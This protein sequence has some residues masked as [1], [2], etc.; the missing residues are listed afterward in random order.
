VVEGNHRFNGAKEAG[1][2]SVPC[3]VR[4]LTDQEVLV[5]QLKAQ[6]IRPQVSVLDIAKRLQELLDDGMT[7]AEL[8]HQVGKSPRWVRDRLLLRGMVKDAHALLDDGVLTVTS[9]VALAKLPKQIQKDVLVD[10]ITLPS[11]EFVEKAR[12]L[13]KDYREGVKQGRLEAYVNPEPQPY[14]RTMTEI[15]EEVC[16][17]R[18]A[19]IHLKMD[20]AQT[21]LDGWKS[22]IKWLL[23]LDPLSLQVQHDKHE[24]AKA[25]R[26]NAIQ[27]RKRN[28]DL[29][30]Q[31]LGE[32]H[33]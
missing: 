12:K 19:G 27:R 30:N 33:D 5:I 25:E 28:R 9:A 7:L 20:N 31:L 14:L 6:A 29:R 1:L 23:H 32:S 4:E 26:L 22:C 13:L 3:L 21:A 8:A 16:T 2:S 17:F 10:A 11:A 18:A 15:R 24:R